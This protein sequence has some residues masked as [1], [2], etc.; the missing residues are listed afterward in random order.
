MLT[1]SASSVVRKRG[2]GMPSEVI[3]ADHPCLTHDDICAAQAFAADDIAD[4]DIVY[5]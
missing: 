4:Q 2:A 3:L 1:I 5:A